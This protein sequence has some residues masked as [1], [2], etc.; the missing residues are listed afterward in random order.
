MKTTITFENFESMK[1]RLLL[2]VSKYGKMMHP[3]NWSISLSI[4][5]FESDNVLD[6]T[7]AYLMDEYTSELSI[8]VTKHKK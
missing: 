8:A 5:D 6:K 1:Y 7:F 4:Y 3:Q 2:S